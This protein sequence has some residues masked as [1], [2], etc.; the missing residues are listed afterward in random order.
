LLSL[1]DLRVRGA[2]HSRPGQLGTSAGST[3]LLYIADRLLFVI[4]QDSC[5]TW[6]PKRRAAGGCS[7]SNLHVPGKWSLPMEKSPLYW[8]INASFTG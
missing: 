7:L 8:L 3:G 5:R 2:L 6:R 1:L 4:N